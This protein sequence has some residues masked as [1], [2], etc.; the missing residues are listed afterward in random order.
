MTPKQQLDVLQTVSTRI[1][2]SEKLTTLLGT[3]PTFHDAEILNIELKRAAKGAAPEANAT[4]QIRLLGRP[5]DLFVRILF[6]RIE[7]L[8]LEDFN[9][10]N[11]I[12]EMGILDAGGSRVRVGIETSFGLSG[13]FTCERVEVLSVSTLPG[14]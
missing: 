11:V 6:T 4:F 2:G 12:C 9:H 1:A 5:N 14:E 7:D 13:S 8:K 3:W 10:Q